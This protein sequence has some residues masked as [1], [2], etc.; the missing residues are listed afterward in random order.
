[1]KPTWDGANKFGT[2]EEDRRR[3]RR[4]FLRFG[5]IGR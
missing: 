1:M 4:A 3:R 5:V 2:A